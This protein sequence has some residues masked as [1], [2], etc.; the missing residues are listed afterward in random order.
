M[1]GIKEITLLETDIMD[2]N[3][4]KAFAYGFMFLGIKYTLRESPINQNS[5]YLLP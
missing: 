5:W 4:R 1:T 2:G 3:I